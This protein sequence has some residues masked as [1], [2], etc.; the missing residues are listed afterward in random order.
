MSKTN[1]GLVEYAKAQLGLPYWYGTFG[2]VST[3]SLLDAKTKQ[4]PS[5]YTTTRMAK[6]NSQLGKRVHDCVGLV[7]GYLWS[8]TPTSAPKYNS[9]Q[10]VSA[11]GMLS[12]CRERGSI[13]TMPEI[14]GVL[15]FLPGH[16]GVYIGGGY[17]IEARG[18]AYGVVKTKLVERPWQ[19]WG[20]CPYLTY[21]GVGG[22]SVKSSSSAAKTS[23][24]PY[25]APILT[26]RLGSRG[27]AVKWA[28][29]QLNR[30]GANLV[31]DGTFGELTR[32]AVLRFQ[33]QNRLVRDGLVGKSTRA[34]LKS[35][36]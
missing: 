20:K 14:P 22:V 10:D 3:K 24:C 16:V 4:Y 8:E 36:T 29:W 30:H 32:M 2:Q 6:Y 18:F 15:V 17:V 31:V 25:S 5:H 9:A 11:N 21:S 7:K 19:S 35:T 1:T 28:Q 23:N 34:A 13:G 26:I 12:V 27:N 33:S